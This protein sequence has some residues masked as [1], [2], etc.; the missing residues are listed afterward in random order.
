MARL[1]VAQVCRAAR[2]SRR[3]GEE[4][5][6]LL[7][8][9]WDD[10][11]PVVLDFDGVTIASVSFFDESFGVLAQNH[12]LAEVT[13]RIRVENIKPDDRQLLNSIVLA[14]KRER[15]ARLAQG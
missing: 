4:L 8:A 10:A 11:E 5:R 9:H 7:E 6:H 14:R 15:E 1:L 13:A 2:G 3:D 12:P